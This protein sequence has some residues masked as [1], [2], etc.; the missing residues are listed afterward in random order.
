M[1]AYD[2]PPTLDEAIAQLD[3]GGVFVVNLD[4]D[5]AD[6]LIAA[7]YVTRIGHA[8]KWGQPYRVGR[9]GDAFEVVERFRR[10]L[11][12]R[13]RLLADI[14]ELQGRALGCWCPR[15]GPCHGDVLAGYAVEATRGTD[16][17]A[18]LALRT[19]AA[20]SGAD[21][22]SRLPALAVVAAL[23]VELARTGSPPTAAADAAAGFF[24]RDRRGARAAAWQLLHPERVASG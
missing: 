8:S 6:E 9:D 23:A 18:G 12:T 4:T 10:Y 21:V 7:G 13:P 20:L 16:P 1:S 24:E 22:P 15:P 3:A 14:G 19:I 2:C 17:A 5:M 11:L